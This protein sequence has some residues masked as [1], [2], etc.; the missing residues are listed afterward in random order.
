MFAQMTRRA[1]IFAR[2]FKFNSNRCLI[3]SIMTFS[4]RI[5]FHDEFFVIGKRSSDDLVTSF[6]EPPQME[7]MGPVLKRKTL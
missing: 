4:I 3:I 5:I 6:Q 7:Y 2:S 1:L